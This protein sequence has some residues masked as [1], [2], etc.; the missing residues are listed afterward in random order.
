MSHR[1]TQRPLGGNH[2]GAGSSAR[3]ETD[4]RSLRASLRPLL[5][6]SPFKRS[7][8]AEEAVG[9]EREAPLGMGKDGLDTGREVALALGGVVDVAGLQEAVAGPDVV[10]LAQ[11]LAGVDHLE[12]VDTLYADRVVGDG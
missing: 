6:Y 10:I 9:L 3:Q 5:S 8:D 4:P 7:G 11:V 12:F 2:E 1:A